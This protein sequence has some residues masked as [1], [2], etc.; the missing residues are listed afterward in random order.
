MKENK[1]R[2]LEMKQSIIPAFAAPLLCG[3]LAMTASCRQPAGGTKGASVK[4]AAMTWIED[5][6][7]PTLNGCGLF[8]EVND[9]LWKALGL[10]KGVPA[11]VSC[12]LLQT[13]GRNILFD[14][15]LGAASSRLPV[16]LKEMGLTTDSIGIICLTHLHPDHI[17]GMM[18][19]GKP[20]FSKAEVYV[21]RIE[22]EA[23]SDMPGGKAGQ[24]KAVLDAYKNQ[25]RLFEAG[26]TLDCGILS[27]AA[28]GHTP[29]H[30]VYRKDS[31][32]VVGDL[33]HGA[34]LQ[35]KHPEFCA[36]YDMDKAAAVAAR[37]SVLEY[38][39]KNGLAMY[40]MHFPYGRQ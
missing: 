18:N 5:K 29:G 20:V 34:A 9:S 10:E 27:L 37:K 38:A 31:I 12:F 32:L 30:T 11:S 26:D 28:Y 17:G 6:P 39:R 2:I 3:A 23:W 25:L 24:A 14:T 33:M 1:K 35:T 8:P 19:A 36:R 16:K 7:G 22:A 13:D 21:N 4:P 15:G 40:G